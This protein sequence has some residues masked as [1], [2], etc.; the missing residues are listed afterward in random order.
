MDKANILNF[1]GAEE[2]ANSNT[3]LKSQMIQLI[4]HADIIATLRREAFLS[5]KAKGFTDE[6][7][8]Y[9]CPSIFPQ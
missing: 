3:T 6:Q 1:P 9:L 7:A 5:L 2:L 8:L 4:E